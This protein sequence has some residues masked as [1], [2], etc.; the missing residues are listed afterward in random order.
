MTFGKIDIKDDKSSWT[1]SFINKK[2]REE[3]HTF[4]I[5][6]IQEL[7]E[8]E[9]NA[10]SKFWSAMSPYINGEISK[11]KK[12]GIIDSLLNHTKDVKWYL[13]SILLHELI[14]HD[15]HKDSM[16]ES[17]KYVINILQKSK[18]YTEDEKIA[19]V[20][21]HL[22]FFEW[23]KKYFEGLFEKYKEHYKKHIKEYEDTQDHYIQICNVVTYLNRPYYIIKNEINMEEIEYKDKKIPYTILKKEFAPQLPGFLWYPDGEYL[24]ISEEVPEKFRKPQLIHE[25]VEFTELKGQKGRCLKALKTELLE[26][27][28]AIKKEYI[29]YRTD[30]FARLIELYKNSE[31]ENFK[32]EIQTSYKF[33]QNYTS[34]QKNRT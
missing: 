10:F 7:D 16:I 8:L 17:E 30:F 6:K 29:E 20:K 5:S 28:E 23:N 1:F 19:L 9:K 13:E 18:E 15:D 32:T 34:Q 11:D 26:V 22:W 21:S 25:I 4:N 24:F 12:L 2:W 3:T 31:D 27:E 14:D 33:L